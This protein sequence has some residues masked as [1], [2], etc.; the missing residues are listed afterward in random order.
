M[1]SV[2]YAKTIKVFPYN[3]LNFTR[4]DIK[5][6][7]MVTFSTPAESFQNVLVS[8]YEYIRN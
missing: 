8:S 3:E 2:H 1:L 7:I 4:R 6:M 5:L